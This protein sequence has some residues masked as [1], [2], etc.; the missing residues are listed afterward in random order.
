MCRGT[1]GVSFL[2]LMMQTM[3]EERGHSDASSN[4][5]VQSPARE[6]ES[7]RR[8]LLHVVG[9]NNGRNFDKDCVFDDTGVQSSLLLQCDS[10]SSSYCIDRSVTLNDVKTYMAEHLQT[11]CSFFPVSQ[12]RFGS[13]H[14]ATSVKVR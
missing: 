2:T 4:T 6:R 3:E 8:L 9:F 5:K 7:Q 1:P 13:Y 10:Q 11:Y 14:R 12:C